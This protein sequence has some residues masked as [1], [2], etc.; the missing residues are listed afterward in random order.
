MSRILWL[1]SRR[2][3]GRHPWITVLSVVGVA[4]GVAVVVA[5][6]VAS[7]SARVSFDLA[8]E[9]IGGRATHRIVGGPG[10]V[11]EDV[12]TELRT[13]LGMRSSAPVVE[14]RVAVGRRGRT[15]TLLG[16]DPLAEAPFRGYVEESGAASRLRPGTLLGRF[17]TDPGA[18]LLAAPT[19][20]AMG[21]APGDDFSLV[22]A[23]R[24]HDM[25]LLDVVDP[26]DPLTARG[27]ENLVLVD[28]ATAQELLGL[29]GR[30]S[31]IDLRLDEGASGDIE[32]LIARSPPRDRRAAAATPP[33][34]S[35]GPSASTS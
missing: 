16:V 11:P 24:R 14:G 26:A 34:S 15:M 23:G 32:R 25:R 33:T 10:G 1:S 19:A 5:V 12:Y 4:L 17:L 18:A 20:A 29:R 7:R 3:L 27:I 8:T 30:L 2:H 6:D 35:P 28:I 31:R 21:I 13:E 22:A 9:A